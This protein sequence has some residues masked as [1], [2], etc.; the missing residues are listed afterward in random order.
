MIVVTNYYS[1]RP[2]NHAM[3]LFEFIVTKYRTVPLAYFLR[4]G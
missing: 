4:S 2:N 3:E 1:I